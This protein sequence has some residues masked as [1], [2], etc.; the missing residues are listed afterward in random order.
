MYS[1]T[2]GGLDLQQ[3]TGTRFH[4]SGSPQKSAFIPET[5]GLSSPAACGSDFK[6][7]AD[8]SGG[9]EE[10]LCVSKFTHSIIWC[11]ALETTAERKSAAIVLPCRNSHNPPPKHDATHRR[12]SAVSFFGPAKLPRPRIS[13]A[14]GIFLPRWQQRSD[15]GLNIKWDELPSCAVVSGLTCPN[16]LSFAI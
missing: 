9:L 15:P 14:S 2:Q 5:R 4:S 8:Q 10:G 16:V 3:V 12:S 13:L 1:V 11:E 7:G 6:D